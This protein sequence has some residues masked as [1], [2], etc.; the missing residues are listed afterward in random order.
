MDSFSIGC[1]YIKS[2]WSW[3]LTAKYGLLPV[4]VGKWLPIGGG[5]V[6]IDLLLPFL[7]KFVH[8]CGAGGL[9]TATGISL[10]AFFQFT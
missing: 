2:A 3:S 1:P 8:I 4:P 5:D 6:V 10:R 7:P 9:I